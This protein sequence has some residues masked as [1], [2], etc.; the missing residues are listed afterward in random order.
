MKCRFALQRMVL[1]VPFL[2]WTESLY[3]ARS[4]IPEYFQEESIEDNFLARGG[5]HSSIVLS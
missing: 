5:C 3:N 4:V 1:S 2:S